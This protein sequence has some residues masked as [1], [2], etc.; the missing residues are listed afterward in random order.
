MQALKV[1]FGQGHIADGLQEIVLL[2][3][4]A[5]CF[6]DSTPT[7]RVSHLPSPASAACCD[8]TFFPTLSTARVSIPPKKS[9][10]KT[11]VPF[12]SLAI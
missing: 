8:L 5:V 10:P 7:F 3:V 2:S 1:T 4:E 6:Q 11:P 12:E 9:K